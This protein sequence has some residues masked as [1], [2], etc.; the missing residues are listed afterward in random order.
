[1]E[2]R[3]SVDMFVLWLRTYLFTLCGNGTC[4][5]SKLIQGTSCVCHRSLHRR[6][7]R[8]APCEFS[9]PCFV[10]T[11][12]PQRG[13]GDWRK[14]CTKKE[15]CN[16]R[17][18]WILIPRNGNSLRKIQEQHIQMKRDVFAEEQQVSTDSIQLTIVSAVKC[19]NNVCFLV[20]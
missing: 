19:L 5:S 7:G 14:S 11:R 10:G 18:W 13:P 9:E 20:L 4:T 17:G 15:Y 2:E 8:P 16:S 3:T 1:M 6:K 12:V